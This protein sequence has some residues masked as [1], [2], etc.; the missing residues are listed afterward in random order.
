MR[1]VDYVRR[2]MKVDALF[3][4]TYNVRC[5][6]TIACQ[7]RKISK[8]S[9]THELLGCDWAT[10]KEHLESRFQ[11][12]MS[13]EDRKAW[14]IDHIIPLASAKTADE[15]F[16]LCHYTNLQPLWAADN[17]KKAASLPG[18]PKCSR[19]SQTSQEQMLA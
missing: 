10:L 3:R 14:H 11:P 9:K 6:L 8:R 5:R 17:L 7:Q 16:A 1:N 13:W 15:L 18:V 19:Q 4:L 12:G 2:R